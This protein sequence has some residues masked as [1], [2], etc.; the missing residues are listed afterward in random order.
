VTETFDQSSS[1]WISG[2]GNNDGNR[3]SCLFSGLSGRRVHRNDDIYIET[4]KLGSECVETVKLTPC[5][6]ILDADALSFKPSEI[7]ETLSKCAYLT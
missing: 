1:Y 4:D 7:P 5:V 6:S 3:T 2:S